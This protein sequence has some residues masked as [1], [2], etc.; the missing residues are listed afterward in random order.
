MACCEEDVKPLFVPLCVSC[1][2]KTN[3]DREYWEEF[4]TESL[5]FL[6]NGKCWYEKDEA[7][8]FEIAGIPKALYTLDDYV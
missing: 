5:M 8:T 1:H 3:A 2:C 6:T 7:E 4:F